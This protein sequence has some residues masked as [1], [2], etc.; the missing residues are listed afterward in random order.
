MMAFAI[1]R[2]NLNKLATA[3]KNGRL[4]PPYSISKIKRKIRRVYGYV[5]RRCVFIIVDSLQ[6]VF[7]VFEKA[8]TLPT[9]NCTY[10][11]LLNVSAVTV[12]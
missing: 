11:G 9:L 12:V 2:P 1:S 8:L 5:P 10:Y 3:L 7:V 6:S 4:S